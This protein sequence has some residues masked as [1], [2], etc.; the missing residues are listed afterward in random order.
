MAFGARPGAAVRGPA[1]PLSARPEERWF[2]A[3]ALG[4][5]GHYAAAVA[6]LEALLAD[7]RVP[8]RVAAHA[9]VTLAAHRRQAGGHAAARRYDALGLRIALSAGAGPAHGEPAE[10]DPD[11]TDAAAA[12]IDALVGLAADAVGTGSPDTAHRLLDTAQARAADHPSWRPGVRAGWVRAEL[13]LVRGRGADAVEPAAAALAAVRAARRGGSAQRH[14]LKSRIVLAVA[15]GVAGQDP[16][17]VV[18]ELDAAADAAAGHGLLPLSWPARMA[19]AELVARFP[20]VTSAP[21]ADPS[22]AHDTAVRVVC[23]SPTDTLDDAARRRHAAYA[24]LSAVAARS[25]P[26]GRRLMGESMQ[27]PPRRTVT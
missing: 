1:A 27:L 23:G 10:G 15:R 2:A 19:S 7:R 14:L 20:G 18:A 24:T 17:A 26:V 6:L 16:A 22:D 9:A 5:Q 3:V 25:D 13:A 4:G 8:A 11:G 12:A 21:V